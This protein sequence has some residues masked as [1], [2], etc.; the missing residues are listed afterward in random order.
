MLGVPRPTRVIDTLRWY[1]PLRS[2]GTRRPETHCAAILVT[3]IVIY[4]VSIVALLTPGSPRYGIASSTF[5]VV[6]L[7]AIGGIQHAFK[8]V[9]IA[10]PG[11]DRRLANFIMKTTVPTNLTK[12][13]GVPQNL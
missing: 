11:D 3:C 12:G 7:H 4:F 8:I 9:V 5:L 13:G 10:A 1:Y 2:S 6:S